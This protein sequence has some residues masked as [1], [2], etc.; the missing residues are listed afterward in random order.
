MSICFCWFVAQLFV[1]TLST[2]M[3]KALCR[4]YPVLWRWGVQKWKSFLS[5]WNTFWSG[6]SWFPMNFFFKM[7]VFRTLAAIL[8]EKYS[9]RTYGSFD[10][11]NPHTKPDK[12]A[13][14]AMV[15]RGGDPVKRY[16][17]TPLLK[18]LKTKKNVHTFYLSN[19]GMDPRFGQGGA[20]CND[21]FSH[22]MTICVFPQKNL[23]FFPKKES[24]SWKISICPV[25]FLKTA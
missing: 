19:T 20:P 7:S 12:M 10:R 3:L 25:F 4:L 13:I 24:F 6:Q 1:F 2:R 5:S 15:I 14:S 22:V 21:K 8:V 23:C 18:S 17:C 16:V 11:I 9:K